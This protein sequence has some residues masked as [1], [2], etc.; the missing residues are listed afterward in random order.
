MYQVI[1]MD[2]FL[3]EIVDVTKG[4]YARKFCFFL[5]AGASITSGIPAAV[6]LVDLWDKKI[7]ARFPAED[8]EQWKKDKKID[9]KNKY[10]HYS[11]YYEKQFSSN[12]VDGYNF[13]EKIMK[14]ASPS[15]GYA[16]LSFLL[17]Q[18][19]HKVVITTNFDRLIEDAVTLY[20]HEFSLVVGHV[21]MA[22]Y[23]TN[24]I[25]RPTVV[26]IHHDLLLDPKSKN[27]DLQQLDE[28]W[29][30]ALSAIFTEYHPIFIGF[31][32]HD[33]DV[34]DYLIKNA[35]RFREGNGWKR[36]Y[37]TVYGNE[38]PE[39]KVED[40]LND[41]DAFLIHNNGFDKMMAK[42]ALALQIDIPSKKDYQ[43]QATEQYDKLQD[44]FAKVQE[45]NK[46][47]S[48]DRMEDS[49]AT[50]GEKPKDTSVSVKKESAFLQDLREKPTTDSSQSDKNTS[51][52]T[53]YLHA[54]VLHNDKRYQESLSLFRELIQ[55]NPKNAKYHN[56]CGVTLHEM[57]RYREALVEKQKAVELEP[58]NAEYHDNYGFLLYLMDRYE[59][60]LVEYRKALELE[61]DNA[62]Y[63]IRSTKWIGTKRHW[64]NIEKPWNWNQTMQSIS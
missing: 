56:S 52:T 9:E 59:E 36:P 34:M 43:D 45:G 48:G 22:H 63:L 25:A 20:A 14:D 8:Y 31:A 21:A 62:E 38:K 10:S 15:G 4:P 11:D 44:A 12:L 2:G 61:P 47:S 1:K 3:E 18:T 50:M 32:G 51:D 49:S 55:R 41:S 13:L 54:V 33:P 7:R 60:A 64:S 19:P 39:G 5:G 6:K 53:L 24:E 26:K 46:T 42:L 40:F 16:C 57:G 29:Q 37:W 27:A 17:T 23:I 35:K 30:K 58:D 28:R